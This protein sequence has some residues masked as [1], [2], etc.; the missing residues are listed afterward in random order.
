MPIQNNQSLIDYER[1]EKALFYIEE[2]FLSQPILKKSRQSVHLSE[3][4]FERLFKRW[5]G[6]SPQRVL[7]FSHEGIRQRSSHKIERC[8]LK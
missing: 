1:I 8:S 6:T 2:N 3:Y 7:A 5:A 4:H